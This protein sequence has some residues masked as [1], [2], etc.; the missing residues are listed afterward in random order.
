MSNVNIQVEVEKYSILIR[1][2]VFQR[3]RQFASRWREKQVK[4][5]KPEESD[6]SQEWFA[7]ENYVAKQE[8]IRSLE[9]YNQ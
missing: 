3:A 1:L 9:T 6:A 5:R 4:P 2:N 7:Y 8:F